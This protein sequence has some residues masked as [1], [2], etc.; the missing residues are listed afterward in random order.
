MFVVF[1][2]TATASSWETTAI[3]ITQ[4][5][6]PNEDRFLQPTPEPLPPE[7]SEPVLPEPEP[8]LPPERVPPAIEI[9]VRRIEVVGNTVFDREQL[10]PI[11]KPLEGTNC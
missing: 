5:P 11:L 3:Y 1:A 6:N 2:S 7:P 10:N 4:Q 8:T 9:P